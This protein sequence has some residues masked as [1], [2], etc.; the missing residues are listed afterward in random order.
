MF[1]TTT[2]HQTWD[3]YNDLSGSTC[4]DRGAA[5]SPSS[6]SSSSIG[7][8]AVYTATART[9]SAQLFPRRDVGREK[10]GIANVAVPVS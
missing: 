10:K 1:G 5:P 9:A 6:S 4:E 3:Y 7:P 8:N 2:L